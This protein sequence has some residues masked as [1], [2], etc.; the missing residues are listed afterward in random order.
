[1]YKS[2]R[3]IRLTPAHRLGRGYD[4]L[5]KS[6]ALYSQNMTYETVQTIHMHQHRPIIDRPV[7]SVSYFTSTILIKAYASISI[8]V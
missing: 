5:K 4:L 3:F 8:M 1:M 6:N 7:F 2:L